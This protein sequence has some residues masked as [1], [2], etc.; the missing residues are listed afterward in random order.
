MR[1]S[2]FVFALGVL[3]QVEIIVVNSI[4]RDLA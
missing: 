3:T 4:N 1:L 2:Y